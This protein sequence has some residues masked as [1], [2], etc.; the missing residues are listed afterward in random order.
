MSVAV[1]S[2]ETRTMNQFPFSSTNSSPKP[3]SYTSIIRS[4]VDG[5]GPLYKYT[6]SWE[7]GLL[8]MQL[9]SR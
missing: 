4:E 7:Q 3:F 8:V 9:G 2:I 1:L 6:T 5:F